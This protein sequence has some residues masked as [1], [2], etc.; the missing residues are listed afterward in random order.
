MGNLYSN[1]VMNLVNK[2]YQK[3]VNIDEFI[4][5]SVGGS[6]ARG[7]A[8][9]DSDVDLI[10]ISSKEVAYKKIFKNLNNIKFEIHIIPVNYINTLLPRISKYIII[11]NNISSETTD[12]VSMGAK[13]CNII[14]KKDDEFTR[15]LSAWREIKKIVDSIIL[16]ENDSK[17]LTNFKKQFEQIKVSSNIFNLFE[18]N[19][20]NYSSIDLLINSLKLYSLLQ[21]D[22]FSKVLWI[23]IYLEEKYD[24]KI[25]DDI[26]KMLSNMHENTE[27][28][29]LWKEKNFSSLL[30]MHSQIKCDFCK[31]DYLQCNIMRCIV[32]YMND[33]EKARKNNLKYGEILSIKKCLEYIEA[34]LEK[35]NIEDLDLINIIRG[36]EI[37]KEQVLDIYYYIKKEYY[38]KSENKKA[39]L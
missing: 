38:N 4:S 36:F 30:E 27:K 33:I 20:N 15:L 21:Y 18:K 19:M 39:R 3:V 17:F 31:E 24:L 10:C 16:Y 32:D 6:V 14:T 1:E 26:I 37:R 28:F 8:I 13:K 12:V 23:D 29:L 34:L 9:T 22:V 5:I 35:L 2:N 11:P 25:K 7:Y